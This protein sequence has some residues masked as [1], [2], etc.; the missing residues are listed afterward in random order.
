MTANSAENPAKATADDQLRGR[1]TIEFPYLDLDNA[2][3]IANNVRL[4]GGTGCEWKQL[5][6]KLNQAADG[7]G[8]RMRVMTAKVYGLL[9]YDRGN[10]E[11]TDLGIQII[12]PQYERR[13]RVDAFIKV[14]LYKQL[15]DKLNSVTL[16]PPAAVE[17]MI[18]Q[19][20]VAPKQKDKARQVFMRSAKQAG[21]FELSAERLSL[22]PSLNGAK[23][24][25][26]GQ[27]PKQE[28]TGGGNGNGG[29]GPEFNLDPLLIAL[30]QKI[31]PQGEKWPKDKRV[32]WFKTFAMNVSQ[33]YDGDDDQPIE[34]MIS[35]SPSA[36]KD[37]DP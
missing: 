15:F 6:V 24:S 20:G 16:P 11:L 1:S 32:R 4:V 9:T 13:A 21:L 12:D 23:D 10:I 34:L 35:D 33:V 5:A 26:L 19:L 31:P 30:L 3:E 29:D 2:I 14:A 22:P 37:K 27:E 36:S 17:R 18:E 25:S 7:G 8:F 28:K